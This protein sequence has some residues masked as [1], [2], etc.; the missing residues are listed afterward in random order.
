MISR[1]KNGPEEGLGR[2]LPELMTRAAP[3]L[4]WG[5][6]DPGL[7]IVP[8]PVHWRRLARRGFHPPGML[9][10]ALGRHLGRPV[11]FGALRFTRPVP[12]SRGRGLKA[13]RRRLRGALQPKDR[14]IMGASVLLVDDVMTTG[15]TAEMAARACLRGGARTVEVACLA[16]AL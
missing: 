5:Q 4:G 12:S 15:A 2:G 1:W 6:E 9:A 8:V 11:I 3:G 13:R 16:R 10:R 14:A 7:V